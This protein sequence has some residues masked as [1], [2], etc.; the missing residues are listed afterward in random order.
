LAHLPNLQDL[1]TLSPPKNLRTPNKPTQY[2]NPPLPYKKAIWSPCKNDPEA[3]KAGMSPEKREGKARLKN[4]RENRT[5][6][7]I[8]S[9]EENDHIEF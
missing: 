9:R 3:C 5:K 6:E 7:D 1:P 8:H 4:T 2:H